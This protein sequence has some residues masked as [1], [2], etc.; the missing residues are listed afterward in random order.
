[1]KPTRTTRAKSNA[2]KSKKVMEKAII[3]EADE[4]MKVQLNPVG[5][6]ASKKPTTAAPTK[7]TSSR[8]LS[9]TN[10][11]VSSTKP[12]PSS[13]DSE[14]ESRSPPYPTWQK[15]RDLILSFKG[16][17]T[18]ATNKKLWDT[19]DGDIDKLQEIIEKLEEQ[20]DDEAKQGR[21]RV[22]KG[23]LEVMQSFRA[24]QGS[25]VKHLEMVDRL[26]LEMD[27]DGKEGDGSE[28][29]DSAV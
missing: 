29:D 21:L 19:E 27:W 1:M 4:D 8:K 5:I 6:P 11:T 16:E 20:N 15:T 14:A 22:F 3:E 13:T 7:R 12:S 26:G 23:V 9:R 28:E 18:W 10:S 2:T 25:L 24:F 17:A